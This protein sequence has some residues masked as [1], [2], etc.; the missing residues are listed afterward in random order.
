METAENKE[1]VYEF[2]KF[3]LD[4]SERTLFAEGIPLH[5]PAKEFETLLLLVENNGRALSKE[6]MIAAI[7]QD[8]YVEE[9]NLAKQISRLRKIFNTNGEQ[10]IETL[11]KHGYRFSADIRRTIIKAEVPVILEK[12]TIKRVTFALENETG[13]DASSDFG[14]ES[15]KLIKH[16]PK[17]RRGYSD[18]TLN[19]CLDDGEWLIGGSSLSEGATAILSERGAV[20]AIFPGEHKALPAKSGFKLLR[21]AL[22]GVAA[23]FAAAVVILWIQ[24]ARNPTPKI[25]TLAVLP[26]QPLSGDED[27]KALGLGLTDALITKL[28]SLRRV[29]VRPTNAVTSIPAENSSND[30]ARRLNVDAILEGTIQQAE[31][32]LRVNARLIRTATGE[33]IWGDSFEQ[34]A[35]GIFALQDALSS[36]IAK[37]LAF[38]LSKSDTDQLIRRGTENAE[39]YDK[40]LRGRFYQSQNTPDGLNRSIELYQQAI[41]L[42]PNF[43]E[44][45]AGLA[46]SNVIMFNFAI[47]PASET[48]PEARQAIANALKLNPDLSNARTSLALIQFVSDRDWPAAE[49]SLQRA[50]E[51]NPNN[52]DAFLRYGYFLINVGRFDDALEKLSKARELNP[53]SSI[54]QTNIGLAYLS[55]R[56]YKEAIDQLEKVAAENPKFPLPRWLLGT[57]YEESGDLEKSFDANLAALS[58]EGEGNSENIDLKLKKLKDADGIEAANLFWFD[59]TVKAWQSR[60]ESIPAIVIAMRAATIK[61]REQTLFWVEKSLQ[62]GDPTIQQVKFLAKFDFV[63]DDPRFQ[64]VVERLAF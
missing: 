57:A 63:R 18:E 56:R 3:V 64:A 27:T 55:A 4:P 17:C 47:R 24:P 16:C 28:G 43:A 49:E 10:F 30:A 9:G 34:P 1:F 12:R 60:Q 54:T 51:L 53:L 33:Q 37:V 26:L 44:A 42:D 23:I 39:A 36:N 61:N 6:E 58:I 21:V 15:T 7:W 31:G 50:I 2:G 32:R 13:P 46:D 8:A 35:A 45:Y 25:E 52:A 40:Y 38:E 20:A 59:E 22:I 41:A 48:I 14:L 19:F 29:V 5:M 11:P 62:E